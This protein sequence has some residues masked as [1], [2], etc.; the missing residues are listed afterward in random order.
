MNTFDNLKQYIIGLLEAIDELTKVRNNS[1]PTE[2][3]NV[4]SVRIIVKDAQYSLKGTLLFGEYLCSVLIRGNDVG[5]ETDQLVDT[6]ID[7]L[8]VIQNHLFTS[9]ERLVVGTQPTTQYVGQDEK[10]NYIHNID[11]LCNVG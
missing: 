3:Q 9:G 5:N 6:V 8:G 7:E 10:G 11:V 4:A 1:L 2:G